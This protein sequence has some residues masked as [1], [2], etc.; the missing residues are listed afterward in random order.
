M[1]GE[2]DS[3]LPILRNGVLNGLIPAPDLEYALDNM[4]DNE[5]N[6]VCL[7]SIDSSVAVYDSDLEDA[8]QVD[9]SPFIDV[10]SR[11]NALILRPC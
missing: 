5:D 6:T 9:F 7:M 11:T 3:G 2:L 1:A 8:E 4:V 10:V